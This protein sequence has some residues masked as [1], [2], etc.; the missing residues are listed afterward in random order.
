MAPC[1]CSRAVMVM[2]WVSTLSPHGM[3]RTSNVALKFLSVCSGEKFG[4]IWPSRMS[5]S[6][7]GEPPGPNRLN[8]LPGMNTGAKN[9]R[10]WM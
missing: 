4:S 5:S 9:P 6:T 8:R 2:P 7:W 3:A 1:G 10:P